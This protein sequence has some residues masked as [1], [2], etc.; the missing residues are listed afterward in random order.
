MGRMIDPLV[1]AG[2]ESTS[3]RGQWPESLR[4]CRPKKN[5]DLALQ[6]A[7]FRF[8][9]FAASVHFQ[10]VREAG[11]DRRLPAVT[12]RLR[13]AQTL[14]SSTG[15]ACNTP[16][17]PAGYIECLIA[18]VAGT[19]RWGPRRFS[20]CRRRY[21]R[22][23]FLRGLLWWE[24]WGRT[25]SGDSRFGGIGGMSEGIRGE[26]ARNSSPCMFLI[27]VLRSRTCKWRHSMWHHP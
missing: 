8:S 2:C 16:L 11:M 7:A 6:T 13:S 23:P 25:M 14:S 24:L 26:C 21:S 1:M 22:R 12:V 3:R 9:A 4:C 5:I 20:P 27:R 17:A 19:W 10:Y 18:D 15:Q